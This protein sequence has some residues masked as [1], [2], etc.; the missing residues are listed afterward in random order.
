M[1]DPRFPDRLYIKT[2]PGRESELYVRALPSAEGTGLSEA[3]LFAVRE[4]VASEL[5]EAE[6][7]FGEFEAGGDRDAE[8][9]MS[10]FCGV[11]EG[12]A[13]AL[14]SIGPKEGEA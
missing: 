12:I 13:V 3:R 4:K 10:D 7:A 2:L 5:T 1:S 8:G 11:L 9:L 14:D 6:K